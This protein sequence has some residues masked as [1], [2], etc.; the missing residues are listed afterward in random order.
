M[1]A[2][3]VACDAV[4]ASLRGDAAALRRALRN[5]I[6]NAKRH[7]AP[8]IAVELRAEAE[9]IVLRVVDAGD[10]VAPGERERAF[11][12]FA[13]IDPAAASRDDSGAGLGLHLV[14]QIARYHGGDAGFAE[15]A[16]SGCAVEI[17]LPA[18]RHPDDDSGTR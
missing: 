17:V 18:A 11:E 13:R 4:A 15:R 10:G 5:L 9:R 8:P 14:R 12:P 6:E 16:G 2:E 1:R 7:G 3:G